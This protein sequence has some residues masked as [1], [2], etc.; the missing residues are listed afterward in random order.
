MSRRAVSR[1]KNKNGSYSIF[2]AVAFIALVLI[3]LL[4]SPVF[5]VAKVTITGN[6]V[7]SEEYIKE[8]MGINN[9]INFFTYNTGKAKKRLLESSPYC[10][11]VEKITIKRIFPDKLQINIEERRLSGFVEYL[12]TNYLYIDD[13]GR[14][15]EIASF[16][17]KKLPVVVGLKFSEF[18]LGKK[19]KVENEGSFDIVVTLA[20]LF[21][22]YEMQDDIIKVDVTKEDDIHLFINK[23]D[24][25]FGDSIDAD[26]KIRTIKVIM[27]KYKDI[28]VNAYLD[29]KNINTPPILRYAI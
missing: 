26:E 19:L 29:I 23:I 9:S 20:Q 28:E 1:A 5:N 10:H 3:L 22:K 24:V 16:F 2:F 8:K 18:T 6:S 25:L 21:N 27:E 12:G 14:V 11:Y 17:D 13:N 15:L 4:I 7:L